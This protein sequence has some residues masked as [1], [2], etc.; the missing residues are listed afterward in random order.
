MANRFHDML[1]ALPADQQARLSVEAARLR[2]E[3]DGM[4]RSCCPDLA[5]E[6]DR[7]TLDMEGDGG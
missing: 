3:A 4:L 6:I 5:D 7:D 1:A 2:A